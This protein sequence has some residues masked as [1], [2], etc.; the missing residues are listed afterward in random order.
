MRDQV[1]LEAFERC[2][3]ALAGWRGLTVG[4]F[5]F[6][7]PKGFSSFTMGIRARVEADPP[8][9]LYRHLAGKQNAILDAD[10]E[11]QVFLLLGEH[12]IAAH[13]YHADDTCRI[14]QFFVGRTLTADDVFDPEIQRGIADELFRFHQLTPEDLPDSTFF[15]LLHEQWGEMAQIGA[16]RAPIARFRR[17]SRRCATT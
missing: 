14:E 13:C 3:A 15:E 5:D 12:H 16:G 8:A 6:D 10:T 9:V 17:M 11:R 7:E 2:Q 4:D 1:R